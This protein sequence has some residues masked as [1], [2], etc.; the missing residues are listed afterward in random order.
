MCWNTAAAARPQSS[1]LHTGDAGVLDCRRCRSRLPSVLEH[2]DL[3]SRLSISLRIFRVF[4]SIEFS[5]LCI[6]M[7][8]VACQVEYN[9]AYQAIQ[10]IL[11]CAYIT[12]IIVI[13]S[14]VNSTQPWRTS[15]G[16][17]SWLS[18]KKRPQAES[19]FSQASE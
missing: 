3:R 18:R 9:Q 10:S 7:G 17:P 2:N 1:S 5:R 11:C 13:S 16:L 4:G 8:P 12:T 14:M 19:H 6:Y 15:R